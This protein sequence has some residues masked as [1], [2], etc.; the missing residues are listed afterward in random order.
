MKRVCERR[1][2]EDPTEEGSR[3]TAVMEASSRGALSGP[4]GRPGGY[5]MAE[6]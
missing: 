6:V 3:E 1:R 4:P 5:P 2:H